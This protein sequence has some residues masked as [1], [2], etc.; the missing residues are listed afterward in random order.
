MPKLWQAV[1]E[2]LRRDGRPPR[3]TW[4]F[5]SVPGR[6][7]A[8]PLEDRAVV[9]VPEA[10]WGWCQHCWSANINK[11]QIITDITVVTVWLEWFQD[12]LRFFSVTMIPWF[13]LIDK[14]GETKTRRW[15]WWSFSPFF[16]TFFCYD[17]CH[18]QLS[19]DLVQRM[20]VVTKV[21]VSW[22]QWWK[23]LPA[24]HLPSEQQLW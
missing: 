17:C 20:S 16:D 13:W 21:S 4:T 9:N 10:V 23:L 5:D 24:K 1:L 3:K 14:G 7:A 2:T 18:C 22:W 11:K 6:P 19:A 8:L 15:Q 12:F